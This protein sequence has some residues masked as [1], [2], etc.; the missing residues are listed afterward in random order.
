MH[1]KVHATTTTIAEQKPVCNNHIFIPPCV[2]RSQNSFSA[3]TIA[4]T[5]IM[6]IAIIPIIVITIIFK[7]SYKI[8]LYFFAKQTLHNILYYIF[9]SMSI[10]LCKL[11][12]TLY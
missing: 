4:N 1:I 9:K 12:Q 6:N 3:N 2:Y 11:I 7:F 5:E 8:F 10:F